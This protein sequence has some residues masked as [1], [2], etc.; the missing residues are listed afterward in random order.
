MAK[1]ERG[2]ANGLYGMESHTST[3]LLAWA[4]TLEGEIR[5]PT[6]EDDPKWLQRWAD[7]LRR[8][9]SKK[10]QAQLHKQHLRKKDRGDIQDQSVQTD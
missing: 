4:E 5:S 9:A 3:E 7:K 1:I 10:V 6:S 8:L 2:R